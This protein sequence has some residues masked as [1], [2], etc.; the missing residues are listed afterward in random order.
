MRAER[1]IAALHGAELEEALLRGAA[2]LRIRIHHVP[3][4]GRHRQV[5]GEAVQRGH[6]AR[7]HLQELLPHP[8]HFRRPLLVIRGLVAELRQ[9]PLPTP[10]REDAEEGQAGGE[11][12]LLAARRQRAAAQPELWREVHRAPHDAAAVRGP[13]RAQEVQV[14]EHAPVPALAPVPL[15]QYVLG[16]HV[17]VHVAG[18]VGPDE[19]QQDVVQDPL[20]LDVLPR[21]ARGAPSDQ[22]V[23]VQLGQLH[24][25]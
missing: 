21:P 5:P 23:V 17:A 11:D 25:E 1:G 13:L 18:P 9:P 24:D 19:G 10:R 2:A 15:Q 22:V 7:R 3:Q 4:H 12:V 6:G 14:R 16:L 20:V 8:L